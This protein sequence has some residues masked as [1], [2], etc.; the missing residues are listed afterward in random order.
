MFDRIIERNYLIGVWKAFREVSREHQ[1]NTHG[2]MPDHERD[3]PSL[4]LGKRQELRGALARNIA[5]ER[6]NVRVNQ[7]VERA[8]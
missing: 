7:S 2:A 1:S 6:Y 5:V 8:R 4:F 3:L